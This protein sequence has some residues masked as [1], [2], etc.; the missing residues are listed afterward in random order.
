[1]KYSYVYILSDVS[2]KILYTGVTSDLLKRVWEHKNHVV[3]GFTKRY[4][5]T[6]LVYYEEGEDIYNAI[7]REKQIKGKLRKKKIALIEKVNPEWRDLYLDLINEKP[8]S[9]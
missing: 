3:E 1:M 8:M 9:L 6:K 2:N 5:V 4:N 7:F